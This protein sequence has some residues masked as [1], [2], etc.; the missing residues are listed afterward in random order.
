MTV[1]HDEVATLLAALNKYGQH[2]FG[3]C[4]L[5]GESEKC[6]CGLSDLRG[7]NE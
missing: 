4:D 6:T 1:S 7:D 3:E 5:L 2:V